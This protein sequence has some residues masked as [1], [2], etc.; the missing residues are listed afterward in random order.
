MRT[1]WR[2]AQQYI[3]TRGHSP[4]RNQDGANGDQGYVEKT[5]LWGLLSRQIAT[6]AIA[7][8]RGTRDSNQQEMPCSWSWPPNPLK[9]SGLAMW[10]STIQSQKY[11]CQPLVPDHGSQNANQAMLKYLSSKLNI[12]SGDPCASAYICRKFVCTCV[13]LSGS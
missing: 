10:G 7:V 13:F 11:L 1:A 9:S 4:L 6:V 5:L 2:L 3:E 12:H 8:L